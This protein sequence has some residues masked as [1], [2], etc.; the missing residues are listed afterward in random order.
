VDEGPIIAQAA[1]PVLP[2]DDAASLAARVLVEEHR[3]YP[4]ALDTVARTLRME[5]PP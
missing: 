5:K 4:R 3:I 1:V 2:E